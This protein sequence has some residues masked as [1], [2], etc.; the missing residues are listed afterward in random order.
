MVDTDQLV[1]ITYVE[2]DPTDAHQSM[3]GVGKLVR[4][5][6]GIKLVS[7]K[8]HTP[9]VQDVFAFEELELIGDDDED[10]GYVTDDGCTY[11]FFAVRYP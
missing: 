6:A 8:G 10:A 1:Y 4:D 7:V 11:E 9:H 3:K 5:E 2:P